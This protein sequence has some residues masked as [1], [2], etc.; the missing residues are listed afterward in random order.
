MITDNDT[1]YVGVDPGY[2]GMAVAALTASKLLMKTFKT[3][4]DKTPHEDAA[5]LRALE[6][7]RQAVKWIED[8]HCQVAR[9]AIER[10]LVWGAESVPAAEAIN[11]QVGMFASRWAGLVVLVTPR[12]WQVVVLGR[13]RL[14]T[15]ERKELIRLSIEH[16]GVVIPDGALATPHEIDAAGIALYAALR[17]EGLQ[18]FDG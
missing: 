15:S 4:P 5:I 1:M 7:H 6:L 12:R 9:A 11:I 17:A 10:Y 16:R 3:A 8:M 2:A 18:L 13:E 14:P